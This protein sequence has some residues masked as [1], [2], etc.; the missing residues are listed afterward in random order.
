MA[1]R[2]RSRSST[3]P[4]PPFHEGRPGDVPMRRLGLTLAG[5]PLE[6]ILREFEAELDAAGI[7]RV[8]PR[9]YL[10]TLTSSLTSTA[11]WT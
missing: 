3:D 4:R 10:S 8:R 7:T 9:F 11:P 2:S 5:T 6:A 1:S